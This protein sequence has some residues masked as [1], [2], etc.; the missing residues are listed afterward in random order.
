[1]TKCVDCGDDVHWRPVIWG[2]CGDCHRAYMRKT[3]PWTEPAKAPTVLGVDEAKTYEVQALD[4]EKWRESLRRA[5]EAKVS[6]G[7]GEE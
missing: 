3:E 1:M 4:A 2:R 5:W 6:A 7:A